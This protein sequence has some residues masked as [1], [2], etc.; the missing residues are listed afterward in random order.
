MGALNEGA[1]K[2]GE[3]ALSQS[4]A[5]RIGISGVGL[6][7]NVGSAALF[8]IRSEILLI[9]PPENIVTH[10]APHFHSRKACDYAALGHMGIV[11]RAW[12]FYLLPSCSPLDA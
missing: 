5:H 9:S 1:S 6:P 4:T 2:A 7:R 3:S 11:Y 8:K 12:N 10:N